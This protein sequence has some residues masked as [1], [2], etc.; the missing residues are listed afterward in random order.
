[1]RITKYFSKF[2]QIYLIFPFTNKPNSAEIRVTR[3]KNYTPTPGKEDF[4]WGKATINWPGCGSMNYEQTKEFTAGLLAAMQLAICLDLGKE[5]KDM[6]NGEN[7]P[8]IEEN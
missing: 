2:S 6:P 4:S 1:M 7:F 8:K 5:P 3:D